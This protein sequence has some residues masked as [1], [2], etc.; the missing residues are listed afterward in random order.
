MAIVRDDYVKTRD[1]LIGI[2][3]GYDATKVCINGVQFKVPN[4]VIDITGHTKDFLTLGEKKAKGYL[5]SNYI[6]NKQYLVGELARKSV[7]EKE[8]RERYMTK[9]E[10]MDSYDRF[11]TI[12]FEVNLMT[13]IGFA[14]VEYA[15]LTMKNQWKPE[16]TIVVDE[17]T[18]IKSIPTLKN[19]RI[20]I[21]VALPNDVADAA[22][23]N[24]VRILAKKHNFKIET[25]DGTYS[26]EFDIPEGHCTYASQVLC[27]LL[28]AAHDDV[29][30]PVKDSPILKNLPT[31]VIDGGYKT[32]GIFMLTQAYKVSAAESNTDFA[33]G[34]VH[35]EVAR[36]LREEYGRG[37]IEA[38][39]IPSI[40]EEDGGE[41]IYKTEKGTAR[42]DIRKLVLE[43]ERE[44]CDGLIHYLND[45]FEDLLD[46]KQMLITGGTGAA[47]YK[48][49][50]SYMKE[51]RGHL[52]GRVLL[53]DYEF[54]GKTIEP[55]Y[56]IAVGI[57]KTIRHQVMMK[58]SVAK[59]A[60][61][62]A[63]KKGQNI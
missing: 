28:G 24:I 30:A 7:R 58:E 26:L 45:K 57:Y 39:Q 29:G 13:V 38:Y 56:A 8:N 41:I 25:L 15:K 19:S 48:H 43:K 4:N 35:K 52:E 54:H 46:V 14:I 6:A 27:A 18:G 2:D 9:T 40:I 3:P 63:N 20:I 60:K 16:Y 49:I 42:L 47:Y 55:V 23:P 12:D 32:V 51:N 61:A 1:I 36:I 11:E 53:T 10:I 5:L 22:W 31:V 21:G 17:E 44:L 59:T 62:A 33:M 37:N 34:N 50:S